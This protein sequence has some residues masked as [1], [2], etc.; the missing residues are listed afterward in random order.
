M[1]GFS[2]PDEPSGFVGLFN[3][4]EEPE[5]LEV[6]EDPEAHEDPEVPEA[7]EDPETPEA[8]EHIFIGYSLDTSFD[9]TTK[10]VVS[11]YEG[12]VVWSAPLA[13]VIYF[14]SGYASPCDFAGNL[15]LVRLNEDGEVCEMMFR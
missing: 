3:P 12:D 5:E 2:F 13:T 4:H 9:P 8:P 1:D 10:K 14:Q 15:I 11:H 7:P 6:H